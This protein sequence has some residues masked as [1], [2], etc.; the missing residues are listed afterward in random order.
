M[1]ATKFLPKFFKE[2][3]THIPTLALKSMDWKGIAKEI[4]PMAKRMRYSSLDDECF[5]LLQSLNVDGIRPIRGD[6]ENNYELLATEHRQDSARATLRLFFAQLQSPEGLCLD[7]RPKHFRREDGNVCFSPNNVWFSFREDFRLGLI[8]LYKGYYHQDEA[9]FDLALERLGL[10]QDLASEQRE[11][12][13]AIF[14]TQ[15]GSATGEV[16][17]RMEDFQES[18]YQLFKFFMDHEVELDKDFTFLGVYLVGL[19]MNLEKL[20][21]SVNAGNVFKE[22]FPV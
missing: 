22:I 6:V 19:Y 11:E 1:L 12:L 10:V 2:A 7:L 18:F 14:R 13:K 15:F 16:F 17:F 9:L 8:E 20:D 5:A 3:L 4:A 21:A